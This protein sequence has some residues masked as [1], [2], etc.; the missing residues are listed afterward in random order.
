MKRKTPLPFYIKRE[1][2]L[3]LFFVSKTISLCYVSFAAKGY[4]I[5]AFV[6]NRA[7]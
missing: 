3:K 2:K 1:R 5:G 6:A 4:W 7:T